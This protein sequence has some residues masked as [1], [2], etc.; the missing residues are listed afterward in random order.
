MKSTDST[1][2]Q[3][4]WIR[5]NNPEEDHRN[6]K[7][8]VDLSALPSMSCG[9]TECESRLSHQSFFFQCSEGR[10]IFLGLASLIGGEKPSETLIKPD[11]YSSR[12][13]N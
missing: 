1:S 9:L 12:M 11:N 2:F 3:Q 13:T 6:E 7:I 8:L 4:A 10:M 5:L